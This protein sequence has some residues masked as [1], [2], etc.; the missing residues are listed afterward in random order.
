MSDKTFLQELYSIMA[1]A[2]SARDAIARDCDA[3]PHEDAINDI[4]EDLQEM[5]NKCI[6]IQLAMKKHEKSSSPYKL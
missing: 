3:D 6:E 4:V 2:E 1:K 5:I